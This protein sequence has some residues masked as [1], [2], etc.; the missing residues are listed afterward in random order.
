[1]IILVLSTV[2]S[3]QTKG[4]ENTME[5][6]YQVLNYLAMHPDAKVRF[7]AS[8]MVMNIHSDTLYL[9]EPNVRSHACGHFFMGSLPQHG[10]PIKLNSAFHTLCSSLRI[11]VAS[12]VEAEL[13][14]LLFLY[15]QA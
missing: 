4:T 8:D 7:W 2:A 6:V 13:G 14:V 10:K 5:K 1:M 11:V 3:K 15:C 12:T 9:T